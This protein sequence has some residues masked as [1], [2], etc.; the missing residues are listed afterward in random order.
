MKPT[1][2]ETL[3]S[4]CGAAYSPPRD[5]SQ[6]PAAITSL[7]IDSRKLAPGTLFFA[8]PGERADGHDF[9]GSVAP[10]GAAAVVRAVLEAAVQGPV[11]PRLPASI[12]QNHP[13]V[14]VLFAEQN[15]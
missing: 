5:G 2:L 7:A 13:N 11:T 3:A 1:T 10:A 8:L 4:W 6:I 12:L 9:L 15:G 14:T